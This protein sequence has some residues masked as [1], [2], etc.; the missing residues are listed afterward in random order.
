MNDSYGSMEALEPETVN[1]IEC[2]AA[3]LA[4]LLLKVFR[5][6]KSRLLQVRVDYPVI[7]DKKLSVFNC[8]MLYLTSL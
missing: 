1:P 6:S 8:I 5:E 4:D 3:I 7:I 2:S